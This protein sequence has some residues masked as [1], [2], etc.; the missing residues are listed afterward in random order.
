MTT[1][2]RCSWPLTF[3]AI[4]FFILPTRV[5]ERYIFP[6]IAVMPLLAVVSGRWAVALLLLSVGAFINLH[7]ILTLPLYGTDNVTACR[8]V[9][10]SVRPPL[11]ML[12]AL[13]QTGV[14]LWAAWQLRP[15]LAHQPGR[16]R[17][18]PHS[19]GHLTGARRVPLSTGHAPRTAAVADDVAGAAWVRGPSAIDWI[20]DRSVAADPSARDRS[21]ALAVRAWRSPRPQGRC[22]RHRPARAAGHRHPWLPARPAGGHVLRRGLP[23]S[24]RHRVPAALGVR[25]APRHLRVHP[26]AP[27]Q[28]R[29]GLGHPAGRRQRDHGPDGAGRARRGRRARAALVAP[30]PD[31]GQRHGDRLYVGTGEALRVYDLATRELV[32][33]LPLAATA[34]AVDD[35]GHTLYIGGPGGAL[36]PPRHHRARCP[37][38]GAA[39][40]T[41]WPRALLGRARCARRA[42]ARHRH[43]AGGHHARL[44]QHLR[45]RD[46]R[47]ALRALRGRGRRCR[48]AALGRA[49]R[50]RHPRAGRP[51][52]S[53]PSSL[54]EALD[55]DSERITATVRPL[56]GFV[57]VDAYARTRTP[58]TLLRRPSPPKAACLAPSSRAR[59]LAGRGRPRRH[60]RARCLDPRPHRRDPTDEPVTAL[61]LVEPES[62]EP[63]LYAA[64]GADL[65]IISL[66]RRG[67]RVRPT[68]VDARPTSAT[69]PGTSRPSWSTPWARRPRVARPSTWSSPRATSVFIDVPL[70]E[71]PMPLAAPTRRPSDPTST[72][73]SCWPSLRTDRDQGRHRWQRLRLAAARACSWA[74]SRQPC[75]T[76][77]R[78]SSSRG[79]ASLSSWPSCIVAEGML[80][81][82]SRIGMNDV[83]VTTFIVARGA[84]LRAAATWRRGGRGRRWPSC[85]EPAVALGL[86]LASKWVALYAIGGLVLLVLF[87][88]AL[89]RIIALLGM[90]ALTVVLGSMAIRTGRWSRTRGATGSFLLLMLLL[91]G[92]L[93][94]GIVRRPMPFTAAEVLLAVAMPIAAGRA[95]W[96]CWAPRRPLAA[97][98]PGRRW[99]SAAGRRS[100]HGRGSRSLRRPARR[101]AGAPAPSAW[102][103]PGPRQVCPGCSRWPR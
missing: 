17:S 91:T 42:A 73:P 88:S 97:G 72:A 86:A 78:G 13:L 77:S 46:R 60:L 70:P 54:A 30:A 23:R 49:P 96:R 33:E 47:A 50:R 28:V 90:M 82:N 101:A 56:D 84:A 29:H 67:A 1:A 68:A 45:H 2:G 57:V 31:D 5:H 25:R 11:I 14:G 40:R 79:E 64:T 66:H 24:H 48:G 100:G 102:L 38:S 32:D 65:E 85:S 43:L 93:A 63:T 103:H 76:C 12:S 51:G 99:S 27:G 53:R 83:Y 4:A 20:V 34:L 36:L 44:A 89:G 26:P 61:A 41:R 22:H 52:R 71:E 87:R 9:T 18:R 59:P 92:L 58:R 69:W 8:W 80:F 3:L 15:S 16:L 6:A 10:G 94:A 39:A 95:S 19:G 75:C 35:D 21:A 81:A 62:D 37:R 74:R 7:A 98:H 55:D